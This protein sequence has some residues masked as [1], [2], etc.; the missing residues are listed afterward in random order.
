MRLRFYDKPCG[1]ILGDV[2]PRATAMD[3]S[4]L[5]ARNKAFWKPPAPVTRT[6]DAT[7]GVSTLQQLNAYNE[8]FWRSK[9]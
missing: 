9:S 3:L 4:Q 2:F 8:A 5:N 1:T 7:G 6:T